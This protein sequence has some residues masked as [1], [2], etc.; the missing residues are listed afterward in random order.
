MFNVDSEPTILDE[1]GL[2]T[3]PD[4]AEHR[5]DDGVTA[6]HWQ[7]HNGYAVQ[8][9]EASYESLYAFNAQQRPVNLTQAGYTQSHRHASAVVDSTRHTWEG[10]RDAIAM[11]VNM[12]MSGAGIVGVTVPDG[13]DAELYIRWLQAM[14]LMPI[15]RMEA[16]HDGFDAQYWTLNPEQQRIVRQ[17][18]AF[19]YQLMPYLYSLMAA[20]ATHGTPIIRPMAYN[21]NSADLRS[22]NDQYMVG[23]ML[24]VAPAIAPG[25]HQRD[26]VLP[27]GD[28]YDLWTQQPVMGD[29]T[30]HVDCGLDTLPV[31]VRAGAVVPI[32][33]AMPNLS[34][35]H[36]ATAKLRVYPGVHRSS[37]YED[38]GDG[39]EYRE[40]AYRWLHYETRWSNNRF[41]IERHVEGDYEPLHPPSSIE[42][43]GFNSEPIK[44]S[45]DEQSAP[46]WYYENETVEIS[47]SEFQ[48]IEITSQIGPSDETIVS[49]PK[50]E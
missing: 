21:D 35:P 14:A 33:R 7:V 48:S 42:V 8:M 37:V 39:F 24:L 34:T 47:V 30:I 9:A 3:L 12:S 11:T 2:T 10:L 36:L 17:A 46:V 38:R 31:F 43:V 41:R 44:I 1:D 20:C 49:R 18:I 5:S 40:G 15:L 28:W 27:A 45:I 22:V 23:D 25:Q 19:R 6:P 29:Q 32:W 26:V 16:G 50:I 13:P 4:R